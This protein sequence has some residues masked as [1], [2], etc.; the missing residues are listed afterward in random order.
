[1]TNS[2]YI[3]M[4]LILV[5]C[6]SPKKHENKNDTLNQS[7]IDSSAR[8]E[9]LKQ[10]LAIDEFEEN[11]Q[12]TVE[13][14]MSMD[15]KIASRDI[16]TDTCKKCDIHI[17]T[18]INQSMENLSYQSIYNLICTADT[19]CNNSVE[20]VEFS[21]EIIYSLL[22]NHTNDFLNVLSMYPKSEFILE[23]ISEPILDYNFDKIREKVEN[24]DTDQNLKDD[25]LNKLPK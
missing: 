21:N 10:S 4:L 13:K 3:I 15:Y 20:F 6:S 9:D 5:A 11:S 16:V 17:L 23:Q 24:S 14:R 18:E 2:L 7:N 22:S 25:L 1:M 8:S 12:E 19:S